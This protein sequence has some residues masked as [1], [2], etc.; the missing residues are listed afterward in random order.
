M[1]MS[2][3]V[4]EIYKRK[5]VLSRAACGALVFTCASEALRPEARVWRHVFEDD[6][7]FHFTLFTNPRHVV[8]NQLHNQS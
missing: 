2:L 3:G 6:P 1:D 4:D 7:T 8:Q 5:V